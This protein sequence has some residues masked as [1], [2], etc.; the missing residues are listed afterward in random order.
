MF[1]SESREEVDGNRRWT[2]RA[3]L[4]PGEDDAIAR[5]VIDKAKAGDALAARFVL[6]LLCRG[7]AVA[8]SAWR[9]RRRCMP[10]T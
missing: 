10:V 3:A 5:V 4:A 8:R 9:C 2:L 1:E 7:R 6:G